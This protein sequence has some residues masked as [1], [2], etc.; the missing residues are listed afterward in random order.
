MRAE[1][2]SVCEQTGKVIIGKGDVIGKI[3]MALL[4][5]GH[6]LLDDV[7]GVG[8]TTMAVAVC[9]ALGLK[10]RR[11]QF[12]PDVLPSDI[13]GFSIYDRESGG[14]VYRPGAL[15]GANLVLGDELNRA[16][17]KTQ[18]ALLEAMEERQVTVDGTT[19]PLETPFMVIATQNSVGAA[20]TQPLPYAQMDRFAMRLSIGYP[21]HA[22]QVAMLRDRQTDNPMDRVETVL[23]RERVIAMQR[24]ARLVT[25]KDS[26]LEYISSLSVASRNHEAVEVGISPRGALYL[27]RVSK[28]HAYLDGRD[29]VTGADVQAVLRDVCAHR[30]VMRA[31]AAAT[32]ADVLD[33]LRK[34]VPNPDRGRRL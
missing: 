31:V 12:T 1:L 25:V 24:E 22:S 28:A 27:D 19:Y 30:I 20:G 15:S 4:A 18:S 5:D 29:Y 11:I 6:V 14:F 2:Q 34:K 16:S 7:P 9:R 26:I 10:N 21:D 33:D 23:S 17:S 13:T 8:K 3:L 32:P